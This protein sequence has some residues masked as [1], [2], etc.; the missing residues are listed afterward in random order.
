M[1]TC[2][3]IAGA[4]IFTFH[5]IGGSHASRLLRF[6]GLAVLLAVGATP[7]LAQ[8]AAQPTY[9][10]AVN[11]IK[12]KLAIASRSNVDGYEEVLEWKLNDGSFP[13]NGNWAWSETDVVIRKSSRKT[14]IEEYSV[15][16]TDL[17]R[18]YSDDNMIFF[19]CAAAAKCIQIRQTSKVFLH[20][21]GERDERDADSP[22]LNHFNIWRAR[23]ASDAERVAKALNFL[24]TSTKKV[25]RAF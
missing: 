25:K 19:R 23:S 16:P 14:S 1:R 18:I 21:N 4:L 10:E 5:L 13:L 15:D 22:R 11:F 6:S 8:G 7:A 9:E 12:S 2:Q 24:L 17:E 3:F 20:A